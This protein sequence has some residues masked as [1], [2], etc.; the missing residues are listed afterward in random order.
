MK[1]KIFDKRNCIIVGCILITCLGIGSMFDYSISQTLYRPDSI[2]GM[3]LASYGQLPAMLC[4][5]ISGTLIMKLNQSKK[6]SI[7]IVCYGI[8]G[9]LNIFAIL[10]VVLDPMLYIPNMSLWLSVI[11]ACILILI[12]D[13]AIWKLSEGA[14]A[15]DM[16]TFICILLGV[17]LIEIIFINIV[18]IPWARPRMRMISSQPEALF[19]PW[20]V[21]G[22]Q[23]KD[24]L[25]VLGVAAEE[26]K[27]FPS[28]HSG[29]A[30]CAIMLG[31]IP[32]ISARLKG[33][34]TI[35]FWIGFGF[36]ITVACSRI[37]MGAHFLSD[38]TIGIS[39]TFI[40]E[41]SFVY[42]FIKRKNKQKT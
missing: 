27:S 10:G 38:V 36:A 20:W 3:I 6:K 22:N 1:E 7:Q 16:K 42:Y 11:I 15:K 18:K 24:Q 29:N 31:L 34:E 5:S 2:F 26:F 21:I 8:G 40:V 30:A 13:V 37:I 4:F 35:L 9:L 19:Q 28:G 23:M 32:M 12:A 39:I 14:D 17:F 41:C 25:M 33:K